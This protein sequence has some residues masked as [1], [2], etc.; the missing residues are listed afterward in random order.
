M[1]PRSIFPL[2][3]LFLCYFSLTISSI[4]NTENY[5]L[6]ITY[7][8]YY[9]DYYMNKYL[10]YKNKYNSNIQIK[11]IKH[12]KAQGF[13]YYTVKNGEVCNY[14]EYILINKTHYYYMFRILLHELT[15][16]FQCIYSNKNNK[17]MSSIKNKMPS[18][19]Y[20][21]FVKDSYKNLYWDFEFEAFYY[22]YNYHDF[23]ILESE[24]MN[25]TIY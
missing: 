22:Q 7:E 23:K 10:Y 6:N 14:A 4:K 24:I 1:Y 9:E 13:F 12:L 5:N 15:H 16:Y 11:E 19:K 21:T 3:F 2:L 25:T 8:K 20:I 17:N 18:N